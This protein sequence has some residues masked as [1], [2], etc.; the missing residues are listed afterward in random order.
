MRNV[1]LAAFL[2]FCSLEG[3]EVSEKLQS[4]PPKDKEKIEFFFSYL[5]QRDNLGFVLF[6]NTKTAAFCSIPIVCNYALVPKLVTKTPLQYQKN[7][8]QSWAVWARYRTRFKHPNI[9]V[10]EEHD[11]FNKSAF[12]QLIFIDKRKLAH[13]LEQYREDFE[14]VLGENF[15]SADF[16]AKIEKKRKLRPLINRD[17]KLLGLILGFGKES[18]TGFK[19]MQNEEA[20]D[21]NFK[22]A[23]RRPKA[24]CIVPVSFRGNPDSTEVKAL[25]E[26]YTK[27]ILEIEDI[28]KSDSFLTDILEK[29]CSP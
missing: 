18:S 22:M 21:P 24:C 5:V 28:F 16:I 9:I 15:S 26:T 13:L 25:V 8:K 7:L 23:G 10:C 14:E 27:E 4:I 19:N 29:F 2:L 6:G 3:T 11:R 20:A 12:L 1:L 17:E